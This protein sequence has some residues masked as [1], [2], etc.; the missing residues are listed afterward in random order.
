MSKII[1]L[2]EKLSQINFFSPHQEYDLYRSSFLNSEL[3]Q[4]YQ[5]IPWNELI[6]SFKLKSAKVG[7]KALFDSQGQLALMFFLPV[8]EVGAD[9][10][11]RDLQEQGH[12]SIGEDA[13]LRCSTIR[14]N[15]TVPARPSFSNAS[16]RLN[17]SRT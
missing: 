7:R 14:A 13:S 11:G 10:G 17:C 9:G 5:S 1:K 8:V 15:P 2:S 3:G 12:L 4:I 16:A 6:R